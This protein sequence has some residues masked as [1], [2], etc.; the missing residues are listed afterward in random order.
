MTTSIYTRLKA[1]LSTGNYNEDI[2]I[3]SA[4]AV[5]QTIIT[6]G[7]VSF[8]PTLV[9]LPYSQTFDSDLG[10]CYT[11]SVSGA[12]KEWIYASDTGNGFAEM[13][14][15]NSGDIEEDW[16]I[17]PGINFDDYSDES[18]TF[19][20]WYRYGTDDATNYLKLYYS[21]N[22]PGTGD[23]T[24]Y[25]WTELSFTHPPATEVWTGSGTIDLSLITGTAVFIG[26]KYRYEAGKYRKWRVDN[27]SIE[28]PPVI[29]PSSFIANA[30]SDSEVDLSWLLN[31]NNNNVMIAWTSDGNFGTPANGTNYNPGS[32][33][34]GGGEVI[35]NGNGTNF[36][37]LNLNPL[38]HYY[39]KAWSADG[40]LVYSSGVTT[41]AVTFAHEPSNHP[42][43]LVASTNTESE[44]TVSWTDA[45]STEHYLLKGTDG[46]YAAI[47]NPVDGTPESNSLLVQNVDQG[48]ETHTFVNLN[49]GTR[50]YFKIFSFNGAGNLVNYK[51]D[52]IPQAD[53]ETKAG[54]VPDVFISEYIEG[55][56]YNKAIEI[57]NR[58]DSDVDLSDFTVK[59]YTNGATTPSSTWTGSG[60]LASGKTYILSNSSAGS[61][62]SGKTDETSSIADFNGNDAIELTYNS[63]VIDRIGVVGES[64]EWS[65]AGIS[66]ATK[67]HILV[68]KL[69]VTSG[70]SDWP[71]SAGTDENNSEWIVFGQDNFYNLGV[72]GTGWTGLTDTDWNSP[73]NWDVRVPIGTTNTLI[74]GFVTTSP[75][76]NNDG[77]LPAECNDLIIETAATLNINPGKALTVYGDISND[78]T[79]LI[80]SDATGTGSIIE[81]TGVIANVERYISQ[82]KWHFISTPVDDANTGVFSGLYLK[83]WDEPGE[84]WKYILNPDSTLSTDMQGYEIWSDDATTGNTTITYSGILNT[85]LRTVQLTNTPGT[86]NATDYS[87]YNLVGN[88]YPSSVNWNNDDG[89][90][91]TRSNMDMTFYVW[92]PL[93]G[94][95]GS[96]T[97][98]NPAGT[99]NVDSIIPAQQ[100][101]FVKCNNTSGGSL[102]VDNT[103]RVHSAKDILK[104]GNSGQ[105]IALK[106]KGDSYSDEVII[107]MHE[108]ASPGYDPGLDGIKLFGIQDAPQLYA[109]TPDNYELAVTSVLLSNNLTIPVDLEVGSDGIYVLS[110]A[111]ITGFESTPFYLE[112]LREGVISEVIPGFSYKF[113]ASA[114]D[115][116][117]RFLIHFSANETPPED[118]N[119]S[120]L[121]DV[122]VYSYGKSIYIKS[123]TPFTGRI[124]MSDLLGREVLDKKINNSTISRFIFSDLQGYYV[125]SLI[126]DEGVKTEKIFI[127]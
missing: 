3:S 12:T 62:I 46:G 98:G 44:I 81:N 42:T 50:Y 43:N 53:A 52:N 112:D 122:S 37:H 40:S 127:K 123:D 80:K 65:V 15:Y 7:T 69:S 78:G 99:N 24:G 93:A 116:P 10:D 48:I 32:T 21:T 89:N 34:S 6:T 105:F 2:T 47:V 92:N 95:Y 5:A 103:A 60:I 31:G 106:V 115:S 49:Q 38:T 16:L 100:G 57:Y 39:Y 25:N 68:R 88:P 118:N 72:F 120:K 66:S 74:N 86:P 108:D 23:P 30:V 117:S 91:W 61:I 119:S 55:S 84:V 110:V 67:D 75:E 107:S 109:P 20:T 77:S 82:E 73:G 101:F 85:G 14:G 102:S 1:G 59:L 87:G 94:N 28:E 64:S 26:F 29:N 45:P 35:Y 56:S 4:G 114:E 41:D 27:I 124:K 96:Y 63:V 126:S 36:N 125:V 54:Y 58:E 9:T 76:I 111:G 11:Y 104:S 51:T 83:F 19:D 90:G 97:K 113:F 18:M 71:S 8:T 79:L 121:T 22:Y 17:L 33:I 13:N 70:N